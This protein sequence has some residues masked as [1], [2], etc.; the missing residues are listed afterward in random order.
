[1]VRFVKLPILLLAIAVACPEGAFA[2]PAFPGAEGFGANSVG[3]RG[4][5]VIKV[6]NLNDSGPGSLR[7][8]VATAGPRIVVFSVSGIINLASDLNITSP[9]IT[10]A[11][12][13]SPGG[14][15]ITGRPTLINTHDVVVQHIRFRI[16][17]HSA[18]NPETQDALKIYGGD[19]PDWFKNPAYNIIIDHC[20]ISWAIDENFDIGVG[21]TDTTIQWTII[22]EG[23]NN[24]GHP[25]GKHSKGFLMDTKNSFNT[26]K[27]SLHHSYLA[28]NADRNPMMGGTNP[29]LLDA[30]N[31]V[32]YNFYGSLPMISWANE[33]MVNWNNNYVKAGPDSNATSYEATIYPSTLVKPL[34][35]SKG[36]IGTRRLSQSADEWS[37]GNQWYNQL[38]DIGYRTLTPWPAPPVKTTVM[39]QEVANCV[40]SAVGATAPSRDSVDARVIADFAN[41]SGRIPDNVIFPT[42]F[43]TFPNPA[44]ELDSDN[45]GMPDSW[46]A[47]NGLNPNVDDSAADR[48]GDGYTNIEEYLHHLSSRSY[49]FNALCMP[50]AT[51][52]VYPKIKGIF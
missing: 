34:V 25:K 11:G 23:L 19:R 50:A 12:Q 18:A 16:G 15:L 49:A 4:G 17:V 48:N 7:A 1:M 21:A 26:P 33:G 3:G 14:I 32:V 2:I 29:G 36:N 24:A 13:T 40:L 8:A 28:H 38:A 10:I 51:S 20:S 41:K 31:N 44:P 52:P 46:E 39:S 45:D 30:V 42:D 43:P 27:V 9:Y 47:S 35:Y 37:V 6:T 5:K 22:S